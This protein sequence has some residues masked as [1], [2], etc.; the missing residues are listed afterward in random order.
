MVMYVMVFS[1]RILNTGALHRTRGLCV[2]HAAPSY[3]PRR[4]PLSLGVAL[5]SFGHL[6]TYTEE[7]N[8]CVLLQIR[9]ET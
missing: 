3:P 5:I 2:L 4:L 8:K 1:L 6:G 7:A 9:V